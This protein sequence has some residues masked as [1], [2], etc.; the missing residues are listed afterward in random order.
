MPDSDPPPSSAPATLSPEVRAVLGRWN[1]QGAALLRAAGGAADNGAVPVARAA[2]AVTLIAPA[3]ASTL[4]L[5]TELARFEPWIALT[6]PM[7]DPATAPAVALVLLDAG[8][9]LGASTLGVVSRLRANG[10]R[11]LFAMNN[12]HAYPDW[13]AV[14]DRNTALLIPVLGGDPGIVPVSARLSVA[15][16]QSG[17]AALLDRSGL[18]VLHTR[19]TAAAGADGGADRLAA[20]L[21][22]VLSDTR[23]RI[24]GQSAELNSG[25]EVARLREERA[26]L[27]ATRDGGRAQ[28]MAALRN[29]MHLARMD[30]LHDA[31][32]RI[33]ALNA[34]ARSDL[35]RLGRR[36]IKTY[37]ADL[38]QSV[39]QLTGELD[40]VLTHRLADV[41]HQLETVTG[42]TPEAP[43]R[44]P[45][46]RT[47]PPPR[48]GPDPEPRHRGVEDNLMI[49]L[50]ASGG[51]GL[52][53]LAVAPLA[54]VPALNY[55]TIP[56]TLLL[57][58][59]VAYWVVRTR[60]HIAE[61]AHVRQWVTDA[62]VNVKA[63][64]EQRVSTAL[65]EAESQLTDQVVRATTARVVETDRRVAELESRVRE[66]NSRQP[67][68]LAACRRDLE[69]LDSVRTQQL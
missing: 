64:L 24:V 1:P 21:H 53:R 6:D 49:A 57:G 52:G 18:G 8:A 38:Q 32:A 62:L 33:R 17:D 37:P 39:N 46:P 45:V 2:E 16:R 10:T 55:A 20:V 25:A 26:T 5:R 13:R 61:R 36:T 19:L 15:A 7:V 59:A 9:A 68:Q 27:L 44:A 23:E 35:D 42:P 34:T 40:A 65:V 60:A 14:L 12:T 67:A 58:A 30:L 28:A 54:L 47:D 29:R 11:I 31:G 48:L 50:G 56:V 51:F 3:D 69:I 43:V 66:L 22:R 63:Q 41:S 4:L